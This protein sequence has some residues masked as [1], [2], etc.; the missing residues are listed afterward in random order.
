M[1]DESVIDV[2]THHPPAAAGSGRLRAWEIAVGAV[3]VAAAIVAVVVTLR[4]DFLAYPGWL[5]M[6]KADLILGPIGVG[7][8]WHR[9]RPASRFGLLL[10]AVGLLQI[11]YILESAS[12]PTLFT[13][14]Y[15]WESV[16]FLGTLALIL[17]FPSGRMHLFPEGLIFLFAV[18]GPEAISTVATALS[19]TAVPGGTI[20]ACRAACPTNLLVIKEDPELVLRLLPYARWT[21]IALA[22]AT[23]ALL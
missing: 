10:I 21:T 14:G 13:I 22:S 1:T 5:A 3:G 7:L 18:L 11:P 2:T 17:A 6:Q 12:N 16:V 4:A 8:Y 15:Y 23:A 20:S 19:S 9:R